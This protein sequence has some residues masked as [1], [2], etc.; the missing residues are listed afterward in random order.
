MSLIFSAL[1][2]QCQS[3]IHGAGYGATY[4]RVVTYTQEAHHLHMSRHAGRTGELSIAVHTTHGIRHT[5]LADSNR[6]K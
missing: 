3:Y 4:H 2:I 6:L 5:P 1:L